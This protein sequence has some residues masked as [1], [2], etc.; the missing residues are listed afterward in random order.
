MGPTNYGMT[1][2]PELGPWHILLDHQTSAISCDWTI[3]QG[4]IVLR[5]CNKNHEDSGL[6]ETYEF[7]HI[8]IYIYISP[9]E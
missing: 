2:V 3:E 6:G 1:I 9:V 8:Y 5:I 7:P 4:E